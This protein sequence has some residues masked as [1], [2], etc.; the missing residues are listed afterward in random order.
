V[1]QRH[2]TATLRNAI[3]HNR[4]AHAYLLTGPRGVG[5]TSAARIMAKVLNCDKGPTPDP[6]NACPNCLDIANGRCMDVVEIDG[7]S[8]R[9]IDDVRSLRETVRYAPVHGRTRVIIIDE[10]HML[11]TEAFNALL[12]TLEEP[13][14]H[15]LFL[16]A[17]TEP[18]KVPATI[19][20]RCQ[21]F[22]FHRIGTADTVSLL[23]R[24]CDAE[25]IAAEDAALHLI[26]R[27]A[28]G[29]LRDSQSLLDQMVSFADGPIRVEEVVKALGLIDQQLFFDVTAAVAG[30]DTAKG[31]DLAER[32]TD[33]GTSVEEFLIGLTEHFR[34]LLVAH[35]LGNADVLDLPEAERKRTVETAARFPEEDLLRFLR[36]VTDTL[37]GLKANANPRIAL[38]LALIKLI[39]MDRAVAIKDLLEELRSV[40]KKEPLPDRPL[41]PAN[42]RPPAEPQRPERSSESA[43]DSPLPVSEAP[44][45]TRGALTL[46][47]V[48]ARWE[49]VI[50]RVKQRKITAG[51]FLEEGTLSRVVDNVVEVGFPLCNGFHVDAVSRAQQ[52]VQDVLREVLGRDVQFRCVKGDFPQRKP[53]SE[54][55]RQL[56][57]IKALG[58]GGELIRRLMDDFEAEVET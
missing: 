40:K 12:K 37:N 28:D 47:D 1:G 29:S 11:T 44:E 8:N 4:I 10:V 33:S 24:I 15:V 27:K 19:V 6:C 18:H 20:S 52:I 56:E 26:A 23:R 38:E 17:T 53:L 2:V 9:S 32:I 16:F 54:K 14:E 42:N 31:L 3:R 46:G 5:K 21:R 55:E 51:S 30:G 35:A 41:T 22:D 50:A 58:E 57:A 25:G 49:E 48:Q 45:R 7:A 13:P 39:R 34:N 36:V 43:P